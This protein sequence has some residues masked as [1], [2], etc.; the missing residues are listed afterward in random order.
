MAEWD[1][2][3]GA[4]ERAA[5][6]EGAGQATFGAPPPDTADNTFSP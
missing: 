5:A 4:A 6:G 3:G 1:R 2:G